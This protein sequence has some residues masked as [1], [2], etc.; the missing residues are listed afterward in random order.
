VGKKL[1]SKRTVLSDGADLD[2]YW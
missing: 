1:L 2:P